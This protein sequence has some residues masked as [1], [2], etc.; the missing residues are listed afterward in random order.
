MSPSY[1]PA[2]FYLLPPG[3][4]I[5]ARFA[6]YLLRLTNL[7]EVRTRRRG[8]DLEFD[9]QAQA[10]RQLAMSYSSSVEVPTTGSVAAGKAEPD[11]RLECSPAEAAGMV[12]VTSRS[13]T[14]AIGEG[15]LPA[16]KVGCRWVIQVLDIDEYR[17]GRGRR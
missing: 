2:E 4:F 11:R 14:K 9:A 15:R 6:F 12:G 3:M 7:N 16:S 10:L 1:R 13:I 5:S 17:V 8:A